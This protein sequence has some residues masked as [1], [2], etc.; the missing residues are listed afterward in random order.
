MNTQ[1]SLP[2][3]TR[4]PWS[5]IP[6]LYF[7]EG[8]PYV[9]AM[10]VSVIMYKRM[11]VSNAD[12]TFYTSLLNLPW[13]FK[14]LW[15]PFVD[16]IRTKRIWTVLMQFAVGVGLAG[17]AL[18]L[19]LDNFLRY[20]MA[21]FFLVAFSSATHDIAADGFYM[22]ALKEDQQAFFVGIRSTFYRFAMIT[23]QGLLV[24][25][26]G[27]LESST[28]LEKVTFSASSISSATYETPTFPSGQ[29]FYPQE[30][31]LKI[32]TDLTG[33]G[34]KLVLGAW[35]KAPAD[36]LLTLA[37]E[38]NKNHNFYPKEENKSTE[39]KQPGWWSR[40]VAT[41]LG[42]FLKRHFGPEEVVFE[43]GAGSIAI[44]R[45]YLSNTPAEGET[46]QLNIARS[47]GDKGI[48]LVE[49]SHLTFDQY[50]WNQP[51]LV[52]IQVD[53][54]AKTAGQATFTV[55]S[56]DVPFAWSIVFW[57]V[58]A[59]MILAA[60]Y[61]QWILPRPPTDTPREVNSVGD[62][63]KG[64]VHT[65][66]TFFQKKK[67][68]VIIGFILLYRLG[69]A[70]L[71]KV[72]GLF[73]LEVPELGGLGLST[74][75]LGIVYGTV[76]IIALVAGGLIGGVLVSRQGLKYW[77]WWM[78]AAINVPNLVYVYLA[79]SQTESL[80]IIN[81]AVAIEQFGY[82]FG[83]VAF[84]LY[85]IHV[86]EGPFKAAHYAICTGFMALGAM[87]PGAISG[88]IQDAIGYQHF[89][90]WVII[91]TIPAFVITKFIPLD[92]D[93]GKKKPNE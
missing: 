29:S 42:A 72:A 26:A 84:L 50:N 3:T 18:C 44:G 25:M 34:A 92:G 20:T 73:L 35:P 85:M 9:M 54:K 2:T 87:V 5:W 31:D 22:L 36:S 57:L 66:S 86:S 11:G 30:G 75:E 16:I 78:V 12:I 56:G 80:F 4:N 17:V 51:A 24:I 89:F 46:V 6:S 77:L 1:N 33:N 59:I 48:S 88:W 91:A 60:L 68:G 38:W 47:D 69:E 82:G 71:G 70:Q 49:G 61:H 8:L 76:G 32:L 28:G 41:P 7:I 67:I 13:V 74:S 27:Q 81:V 65:F 58:A 62:I 10:I 90:I 40:T 14:W 19:P 63:M 64:F 55:T 93:F 21:F 52:V 23:G 83:F 39:K 37:R 53:P 15:S 45:F 79:Y 43:K